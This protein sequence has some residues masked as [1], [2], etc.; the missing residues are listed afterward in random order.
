VLTQETPMPIIQVNDAR[1][2]YTD[3]GA[4]PEAIVF[5]HG[6]LWSGRMFD[7]QV[8]ALKD[9]YR[10]ITFDFRGQGQSQ[11]TKSGYDIETLY[12]DTCALIEALNCAPCHFVG[13][14]M[15][16]FVAMRLAARRPQLLRS[17]ILI[18]TSADPE[19]PENV[20]RYRLLN[21]IARWLSLSLVRQ[22]V[23]NIMFGKTFLND[24]LR[25]A[26][27]A[28]MEKRLLANDR[29][30]I[31]RATRGV[32]ERQ[33]V[34]DEIARI[35]LPTLILVGAEDVATTPE[36]SE[37]IYQ[38]IPNSKLVYIPAAGH[39]SCVENAECVTAE[40]EA[41]LMSDAVRSASGAASSHTKDEARPV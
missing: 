23:M 32:I 16:G 3:E 8:R 26:E 35:T 39:T 36:K 4:G 10:C 17:V 12:E 20:P 40:I 18:E 21:F 29:I 9:R 30:G 2:H 25:A 5:A 28:E 27:R 24:P 33:G 19:P 41:F 6:L 1:I 34:Y 15:G 22:P 11:V 38:R 14:S 31:S 13:L 37:R 7:A